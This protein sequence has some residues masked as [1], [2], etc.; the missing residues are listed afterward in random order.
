MAITNTHQQKKATYN[1][2]LD[3]FRSPEDAYVYTL[4]D[5]LID[6]EWV[7]VRNYEEFVKT[8]AWNFKENGVMPSMIS[9]DHDLADKHYEHQ[10]EIDYDSYEEKTGYDCAKWLVDFC[11]DNHAELPSYM[12]H[13]MNTVGRRNITSYIENYKKTLSKT[14]KYVS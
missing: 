14:K 9:F 11:M 4:N 3:D 12:V 5:E 8:I 7:I 1:L 13:S 6:R 10:R 2:F